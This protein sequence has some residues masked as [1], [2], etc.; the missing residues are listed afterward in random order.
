MM[1]GAMGLLSNIEGVFFS[2]V[3]ESLGVTRGAFSVQSTLFH[4]TTG[5][6][7]PVVAWL[8]K[9]YPLRTLLRTGALL[10]AAAAIGMGAA[11][12]LWMFYILAV[13]KG[14]GAS[15]ISLL[16][17]TT[18]IGNWFRARHGMAVGIASAFSGVSGAVFGPLVNEIILAFNWRVGYICVGL[19]S[20]ALAL[21][22]SF[23]LH[24][25]PQEEGL[26]P[27]GAE[28]VTARESQPKTVQSS[29][30]WAPALILM[31]VFMVLH[32]SMSGFNQHFPGMAENWGYGARIGAAMISACMVGN[33]S[34]K[35]LIG[36]ISDRIGIYRAC[37]S[38]LTIHILAMTGLLVLA[39]KSMYLALAAAFLYA[40]MYAVGATGAPLLTRKLFGTERY[41]AAYSKVSTCLHIGDAVSLTGI[42]ML[43]DLTGGYT[44]AILIAVGIDIF[45]MLLLTLLVGMSL[46]KPA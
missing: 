29:A 27:Y 45:N 7:S 32:T 36:V 42:G 25:T 28:H 15:M 4:L 22:A 37:L 14:I 12:Q 9:R 39:P 23:N 19:L 11:N 44:V 30:V 6:A 46:K 20:L 13:I 5:F 1:A 8:M 26:Q 40:S 34:G 18:V 24:M 33:V 2:P 35:L 17:V 43:F 21:P 41:A 31:C 3:M 10:A 16:P 38:M